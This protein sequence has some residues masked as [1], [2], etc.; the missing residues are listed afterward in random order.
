MSQAETDPVGP[1][2]PPTSTETSEVAVAPHGRYTVP[3]AVLAV[4]LGLYELIAGFALTG[5]VAT[6]E[7][8]SPLWWV[9]G[10][11]H[12]VLGGLLIYGSVATVRRRPN[13][14]LLIAA[15]IASL[16]IL[17]SAVIKIVNGVMPF[18]L[19]VVV[20]YGVLGYLVRRAG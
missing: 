1:E 2:E 4:V 3:I 18:E 7:G 5:A 10:P 13:G 20:L 11:L 14:I 17:V 12:L 16:A 15:V 9:T 8:A 6:M 19:F